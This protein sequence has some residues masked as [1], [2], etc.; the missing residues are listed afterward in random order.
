MSDTSKVEIKKNGLR[1]N[2]ELLME[3]ANRILKYEAG[4]RT[5]DDLLEDLKALNDV[6][7]SVRQFLY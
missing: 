1:L 3:I 2:A 4:N 5:E 6:P 7:R